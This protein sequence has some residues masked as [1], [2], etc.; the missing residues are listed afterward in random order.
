MEELKINKKNS[1]FVDLNKFDYLAKEHDFIEITD[2]VN[3]EGWDFNINETQISL[4]RGTLDAIN[5]LVL[6]LDSKILKTDNK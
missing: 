4:S 5:F 6:A 1:I 3:G 2:W